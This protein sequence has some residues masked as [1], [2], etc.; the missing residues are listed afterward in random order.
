M[1]GQVPSGVKGIGILEN[2]MGKPLENEMQNWGY[3]GAYVRRNAAL[4][5]PRFWRRYEILS[6]KTLNPKP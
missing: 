2:Q 1:L 6:G 4:F 3:K 5:G